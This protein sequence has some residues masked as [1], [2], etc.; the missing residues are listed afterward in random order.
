[1]TLTKSNLRYF[2]RSVVRSRDRGYVYKPVPKAANTYIKYSIWMQHYKRGFRTPPPD[3]TFEVHRA[4]WG[5]EDGLHDSPWDFYGRNEFDR[6][7]ADFVFEDRLLRFTC[8]RNPFARLLSAYLERIEARDLSDDH[9][10]FRLGLPRKPANYS[11]FVSMVGDIANEKRNIHWATQVHGLNYDFF[12][13]DRVFYFE[14]L[15]EIDDFIATALFKDDRN[16]DDRAGLTA[17]DKDQ[18]TTD[19]APRTN[20]DGKIPLYYDATI[21]DAVRSIYDEDFEALGYSDD[22]SRLISE[23]PPKQPGAQI[24]VSRSLDLDALFALKA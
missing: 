20:A 17:D 23:R 2:I 16:K 15:S 8:V 18:S 1:M 11:E 5:T 7:F 10:K 22:P 9:I 3:G 4:Q 13:Y 14:N 21:V 24:D 12:K 6:L 19:I